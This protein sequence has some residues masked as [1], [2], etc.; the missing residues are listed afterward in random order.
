MPAAACALDGPASASPDAVENACNQRGQGSIGVHRNPRI[1]PSDPRKIFRLA[2]SF[3]EFRPMRNDGIVLR[4]EPLN[5]V[6]SLLI[7]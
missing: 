7:R 1:G 3:Y 6:R 4:D 5:S 2:F